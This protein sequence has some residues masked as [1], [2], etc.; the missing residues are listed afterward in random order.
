MYIPSQTQIHEQV[1]MART[2]W[3]QWAV[4]NQP[5]WAQQCM[6]VRNTVLQHYFMLLCVVCCAVVA[7]RK[8]SSECRNGYF[9]HRRRRLISVHMHMPVLILCSQVAFDSSVTGKC[10]QQAQYWL[11]KSN[12]LF[13]SGVDMLPGESPPPSRAIIVVDWPICEAK[14]LHRPF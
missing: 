6:Q 11:R 5:V 10:A 1:E 7:A 13:K 14:W 4:N 9:I 2:C 12:S 8:I 3:G